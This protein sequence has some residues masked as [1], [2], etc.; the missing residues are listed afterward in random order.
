M[1][2]KTRAIRRRIQSIEST[3]QITRTME[4]VSASK[5]KRAQDRVVAARPFTNMVREVIGALELDGA[6]VDSPL[7]RIPEAP[8]ASAIFLFTS[9]RGLCG[10][11]NMNL[12]FRAVELARSLQRE[13]K[14]VRLH[15]AGKKGISYFRFH[16]WKLTNAW[17][18]L[19]DRP[20]F[21]E[22]DRVSQTVMEEFVAQ[23]A[24]EV[25]L[26][27]ARFVSP[28]QTPVTTDRILPLSFEKRLP[29]KAGT[30]VVGL[31]DR[32]ERRAF[33]AA[34]IFEPSPGAI[35]RE[36][37]PLYVRNAVY[38]A[39][40][41]NAASEHGA[42]RTAMKNATDNASDVIVDLTRSYNKARQAQITQE[43]AELMGGTEAL[44]AGR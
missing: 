33:R 12:N 44:K 24:D 26:V 29:P 20:T 28:V 9:N 38:R 32:P 7:L 11:F 34:Y 23:R 43:I 1:P 41:E 8:K 25:F 19:S 15:V 5:L 10:A 22:A 40:I 16:G 37:L 13:G 4:L 39:L 2:E 14:A 27:F 36:I 6:E 3:R 31:A 17:T 18:E 35:L 30:A 21:A 42:R